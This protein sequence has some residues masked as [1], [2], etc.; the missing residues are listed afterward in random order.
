[1]EKMTIKKTLTIIGLFYGTSAIAATAMNG[2]YFEAFGGYTHQPDN[3]NASLTTN[4]RYHSGFNAGGSVGYKSGPFSYSLQGAYL[5]SSIRK[6]DYNAIRQTSV[7]GDSNATSLLFNGY[8][9]FEDMNPSLVPFV[10]M[11]LGYTYRNTHITS[12]QPQSSEFK[13]AKYLFSYN[14]S[15]GIT[16]NYDEKMAVGVYYQYL[17]TEKDERF[18]KALQAHMA[19]LSLIYRCDT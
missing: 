8:Y 7:S 6:F 3:V 4:T 11:G 19:N 10:G 5:H 9:L 12:T 16:Y 17:R 15:A 18:G 14:G 1:M 13:N 2:L